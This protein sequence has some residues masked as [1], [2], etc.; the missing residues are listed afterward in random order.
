M[1]SGIIVKGIKEIYS[2]VVIGTILSE[3][4]DENVVEFYITCLYYHLPPSETRIFIPQIHYVHC[5]C[6][7]KVK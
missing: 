7:L 1:E 3:A 2:V 4:V 5:N 6:K